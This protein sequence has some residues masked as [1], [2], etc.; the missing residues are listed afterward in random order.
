MSSRRRADGTA[1]VPRDFYGGNCN[2]AAKSPHHPLVWGVRL[3]VL[4]LL[5]TSLVWSAG[6]YVSASS[7][8]YYVDCSGGNDTNGGTSHGMAEHIAGR[9]RQAQSRRPAP[10]EAGLHVVATVE[11]A[12]EWNRE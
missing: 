10:A 5:A 4:A 9:K 8:T 1:K 11:R 3:L 2:C 12:L 7:T 6:R